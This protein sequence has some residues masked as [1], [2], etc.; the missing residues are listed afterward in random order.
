M[1][2]V[3]GCQQFIKEGQESIRKRV[4]DIVKEL[5]VTPSNVDDYE[6]TETIPYDRPLWFSER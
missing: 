5:R 6:L 1:C 3:C 4:I 2:Q